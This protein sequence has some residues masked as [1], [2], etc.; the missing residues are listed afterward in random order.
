MAFLDQKERILD[1][2]LTDYGRE[3]LA[4]NQLNFV[5]YCFSDEG[6]DYSGSLSASMRVSSTLDNYIRRDVSFEADQRQNITDLKSFL[7]TIPAEKQILPE[8]KISVDLTSS[9]EL[10]RKYQINTLILQNKSTTIVNKPIDVVIRATIP[11]QNTLIREQ[12]YVFA[13]KA[14]TLLNNLGKK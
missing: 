8:F 4:K 13:Q 10:E 12:S 2:V 7:Y 14:E 6:I 1:V 11:K 3:L 5:F 9:I